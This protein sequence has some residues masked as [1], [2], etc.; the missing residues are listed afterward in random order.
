[1]SC[2]YIMPIVVILQCLDVNHKLSEIPIH[3]IYVEAAY[4]TVCLAPSLWTFIGISACAG[5]YFRTLGKACDRR[6]LCHTA[7]LLIPMYL[8]RY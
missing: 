8:P 5:L 3:D 7:V 1:M 4:D 2:H 6:L